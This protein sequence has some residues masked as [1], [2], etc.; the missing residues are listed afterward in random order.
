MKLEAKIYTFTGTKSPEAK[1][2]LQACVIYNISKHDQTTSQIKFTT[3]FESAEAAKAFDMLKGVELVVSQ[4][5]HFV[6]LKV[7]Q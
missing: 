2:G 7:I 5:W 3:P 1:H 4:G 6:V